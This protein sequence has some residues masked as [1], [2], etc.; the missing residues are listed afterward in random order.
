MNTVM[1]ALDSIGTQGRTRTGTPVKAGDFESPVSTNST[2]RADR[3][4]GRL[5]PFA[6]SWEG[7]SEARGGPQE[8]YDSS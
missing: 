5:K 3:S 6:S 8:G 4:L 2:T 7:F 1:Q